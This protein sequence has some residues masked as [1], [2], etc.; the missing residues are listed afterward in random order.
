[1]DYN[2]QRHQTL[3]REA[4]S[5]WRS[6]ALRKLYF[7]MIPALITS[8][9]LGFDIMM[10][11]SLQSVQYFMDYFGKPRG[12]ELGFYGAAMSILCFVGA[13]LIIGMAVMET[14]STSFAMF[15]G[16]KVILGIGVV[17]EQVASPVLVTELAHPKQRVTV[18]NIYNTGIYVGMLIG[19]W[20]TF[21]TYSIQSLW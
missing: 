14:F 5:W 10:T 8:T 3:I 1:M 19:A 18:T 6:P 20:I 9:A 7:S 16:A 2:K 4:P 15:N 12:A 11:N 13:L 21:G 17:L